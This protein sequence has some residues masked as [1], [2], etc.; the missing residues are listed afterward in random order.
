M[1][2]ELFSSSFLIRTK[3]YYSTDE[4]FILMKDKLD[5]KFSLIDRKSFLFVDH[6]YIQGVDKFKI[7]LSSGKR[8]L[9]DKEGVI[10]I[11]QEDGRT[12][13]QGIKDNIPLIVFCFITFG[14]GL[15]IYRIYLIIKEVLGLDG[16]RA[17]RALLKEFA[18]EIEKQVKK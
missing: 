4:L 13:L 16:T 15:I 12:F 3:P 7:S 10:T 6:I 2:R 14:V 1:K 5:A 18:L 8:G 17:S 11:S 9:S